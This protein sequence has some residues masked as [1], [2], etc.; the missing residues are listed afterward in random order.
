MKYNIS[1][2]HNIGTYYSNSKGDSVWYVSLLPDDPI[3][4]GTQTG[5]MYLHPNGDV[6]PHCGP[7]GFHKSEQDARAAFI[8]YQGFLDDELFEI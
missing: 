6:L 5:V 4:D 2:K 8:K 7:K 3:K 1:M